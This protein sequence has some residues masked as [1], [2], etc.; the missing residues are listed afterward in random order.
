MGRLGQFL[1]TLEP[2]LVCPGRENWFAALKGLRPRDVKVII[3]G[4]D[5]YPTPGDANGCAFAVSEDS[6]IPR[7]LRN[8]MTVARQCVNQEMRDKNPDFEDV[9]WPMDRTLGHWQKQ[10][11]LLLNTRLTTEVG[12]RNAHV[13]KG[14]EAVTRAIMTLCAKQSRHVVAMLWGNDAQKQGEFLKDLGVDLL[15]ASHPSPLGWARQGKSG[16]FRES[17]CFYHVNM[18]REMKGLCRIAWEC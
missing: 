16:S 14:W 10:G 9:K 1:S 6:V 7:S 13:N 12:K 8:I 4:Q 2:R 15:K 11:V 17:L 5:P 3:L 18:R